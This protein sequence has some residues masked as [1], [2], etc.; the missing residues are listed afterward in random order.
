[1]KKSHQINRKTKTFIDKFNTVFTNTVA[2]TLIAFSLLLTS[3]KGQ[4]LFLGDGINDEFN[5]IMQ[6]KNNL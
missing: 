1:M 4:E 5:D 2:I 6:K 3:A